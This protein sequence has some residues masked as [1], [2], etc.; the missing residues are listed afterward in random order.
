MNKVEVIDHERVKKEGIGF[1]LKR[2]Q[3]AIEDLQEICVNNLTMYSSI[4]DT[5]IIEQIQKLVDTCNT[6]IKDI[7]RFSEKDFSM[8]PDDRLD[9]HINSIINLSSPMYHTAHSIMNLLI[10]KASRVESREEHKKRTSDEF[11]RLLNIHNKAN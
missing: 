3:E 1:L 5:E 4:L 9:K 2:Q 6:I 11:N 7:N 8:F 10:T